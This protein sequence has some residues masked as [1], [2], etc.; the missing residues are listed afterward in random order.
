VTVTS[1]APSGSAA[2]LV[3]DLEATRDETLGFFALSEKELARTYAPGKWSIRFL[4]HHLADSETVL[5]ER[6]RR[7]LCEPEQRLMAFDQ[8]AWSRELDYAGMPLDISRD[9]FAA[10]RKGVIRL[11]GLHYEARGH[12]TFVH[13]T[14]GVRTLRDELEKVA[15]HN[16]HHLSHIRAALA[17]REGP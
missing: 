12:L 8:E 14:M 10:V 5:Y 6:I 7:V 17:R 3:R 16:A 13:S 2:A 1:T 9:V 15:A 4:L 11:A